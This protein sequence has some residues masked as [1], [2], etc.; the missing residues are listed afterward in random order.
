M[1][2]MAP[3]TNIREE[4]EPILHAHLAVICS[5]SQEARLANLQ[6]GTEAQHRLG[7]DN[8][9]AISE[10]AIGENGVRIVKL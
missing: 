2:G 10:Q 6:N 3:L 8:I 7:W 5:A 9:A 1:S 4:T